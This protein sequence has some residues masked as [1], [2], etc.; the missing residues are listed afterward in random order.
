MSDRMHLQFIIAF[1]IIREKIAITS[2]KFDHDNDS[3][4]ETCA[5]GQNVKVW[6][7]R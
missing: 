5:L 4:F 7:P 2:V 1:D 6:D 3:I